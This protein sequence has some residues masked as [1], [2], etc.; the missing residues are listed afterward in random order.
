MFSY[1]D[2]E[3]Y[4]IDILQQQ[5]K[6]DYKLAIEMTSEILFLEMIHRLIVC[7]YEVSLMKNV[8]KK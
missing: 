7:V 8:T 1:R 4:D 3:K 5:E 6:M 2:L